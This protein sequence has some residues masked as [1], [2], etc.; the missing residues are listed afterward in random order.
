M[1]KEL[2]LYTDIF[3][4]KIK[5]IYFGGGTPSVLTIREVSELLETAY[6]FYKIQPLEITFEANPEDLSLEYLNDLKSLGIN[7]L[8]MGVQ[9]FDDQLLKSINRNHNAKTARRAYEMARKSG[10]SNVNLDL[11][12]ALPGSTVMSLAEDLSI[13]NDL[14]P[15]HISIYSFTIEPKTVFENWIRKGKITPIAEEEEASQFEQIMDSLTRMGFEHYEISNFARE[16]KYSEHNK[17]YWD[18]THYLGIGPSAH[19]FRKEKRW[20]NPSHNL[21]YIRSL[22][23][24]QLPRVMEDR[25]KFSTLNEYIFTSLRTLWGCNLGLIKEQF[26]LDLLSYKNQ[27]T[28][29]LITL[30]YL[31]VK[32]DVLYTT[33]KGKLL[34]DEI[35]SRLMIG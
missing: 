1:Q 14:Q 35:A 23:E 33:K 34:A 24:N 7:R 2:E 3:E 30:G 20:S 21:N 28:K 13:M 32:G 12:Y 22:T 16:G 19:S 9:T 5:T 26:G 6:S 15:E 8:S 29:E 17:S 11:I 31:E 4:E 27:E 25:E 10:F 18:L